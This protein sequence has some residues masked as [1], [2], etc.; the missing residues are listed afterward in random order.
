M[1]AYPRLPSSIRG[2]LGRA[3]RFGILSTALFALAATAQSQRQPLFQAGAALVDITPPLG[4]LI[5]GGWNP[6]PATY[7]HDAL[8]ARAL[9][10]DDGQTRLA[11]VLCDNVG[12]PRTVF[13]R[14]KQLT[15]AGVG[16]AAENVLLAAT[17]THSASSARDSQ[18]YLRA[19]TGQAEFTWYQEFLAQRIADCIAQAVSNLQPA[20]IGWGRGEEPR[21]V[22]NRRWFMKDGGDTLNPFGGVDRVRM[23]PPAASDDL[24]EPAGPTDPEIV[25][26]SVQAL[27]GSPLALLA[28]Y[29]L[30]YVGGVPAGHISADY[31]ALFA[32]QIGRMLGA[33]RSSPPFVGILSNG[34]SGDVNNIN[35][36]L[37]RERRQPYEKMRLVANRVAG[38]VFKAY[39]DVEHRD[40]VPLSARYTEISLGTRRVGPEQLKWAQEV[41]ARPETVAPNHRLERTYAERTLSMAE[42]PPTLPIPLQAFRIG[43]LAI[44]AVPAEVFTDIGL[45]L[46]RRSP[47]PGT[48][49]ISLANGWYGYLPTVEHHKLGGYETWLGTS[50]LEIEAAPK[51]VEEL[52]GMFESLR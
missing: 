8:H 49:T 22:F 48:F 17:H 15:E 42:Y 20:R 3:C 46:K 50:R 30:H 12:I 45:E 21:E 26:I 10:L 36:R 27:D 16:L 37:P 13:D 41:L 34:T 32:D 4:E 38:E 51:I 2:R 5:V 44:A 31:F 6:V 25:F 39:Q 14:A 7:I 19:P 40:W 23:N 35:F 33:D 29:S 11:V 24:L 9:V 18:N 52:L 47:F 1:R 28:N 43:D